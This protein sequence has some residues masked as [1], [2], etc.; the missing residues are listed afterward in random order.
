MTTIIIDNPK[1]EKKYSSYEIK[2]KFIN[3]LE[4]DLKED[5]IDLY[6]ISE[7]NLSKDTQKRLKK[8]DDLNFV[9]Y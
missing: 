6:E 5:K 1:L 7:A 3:F 9:D 4:K 8:I 2:M